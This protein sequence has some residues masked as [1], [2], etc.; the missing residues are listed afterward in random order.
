MLFKIKT[1]STLLLEGPEMTQEAF[2]ALV[3]SKLD[4][5]AQMALQRA[6]EEGTTV[7]WHAIMGCVVELVLMDGFDLCEAPDIP[8]RD[9]MWSDYYKVSKDIRD[10]IDKYEKNRS[11]IKT[12]YLVSDS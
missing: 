5:A 10:E 7:P 11:I 12:H 1:F 2:C 9:F 8:V 3:D 4:Q 6:R